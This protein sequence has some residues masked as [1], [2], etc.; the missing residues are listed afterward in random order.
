MFQG[1]RETSFRY[2]FI[3]VGGSLTECWGDTCDGPVSHPKGGGVDY[4][5]SQSL[6]ATETGV[7][8]VESFEPDG[9][10][11][12]CLPCRRRRVTCWA[13]DDNCST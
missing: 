2:M 7:I 13:T 3:W 1:F 8:S 10:A 11:V 9:L 5:H 6:H 4:Q 12:L